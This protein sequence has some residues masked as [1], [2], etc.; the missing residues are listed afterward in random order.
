M[1][2][3]ARDLEIYRVP[4]KNVPAHWED[5]QEVRSEDQG[6]QERSGL[7][8]SW[9]TDPR[10]QSKGD[11]KSSVIH[12]SAITDHAM[13]ENNVIN[14]DKAKWSIERHSDKPDL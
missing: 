1:V 5:R 10:L 14:W 8:H 3:G 6:A 2:D 7:F 13:E 11:W 9:Y 4:C 12:K